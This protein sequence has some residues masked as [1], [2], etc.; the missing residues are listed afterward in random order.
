MRIRQVIPAWRK[1]ESKTPISIV[2]DPTRDWFDNLTPLGNH[3]LARFVVLQT[4]EIL[5]GDA[6]HVLHADIKWLGLDC[7][8]EKEGDRWEDGKLEPLVGGSIVFDPS[9][10]T[11]RVAL[12]QFYGY[13]RDGSIVRFG[14]LSKRLTTWQDLCHTLGNDP[15]VDILPTI[16]EL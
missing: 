14:Q 1:Y 2:S 16:L 3:K 13:G 15:M 11:W 12:I 8:I 4:G 6:Y 5:F 7:W 9:N 10:N